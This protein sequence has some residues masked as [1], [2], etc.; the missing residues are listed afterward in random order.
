M[1][2]IDSLFKKPALPPTTGKKRKAE[3]SIN[4]LAAYKSVRLDDADED[5]DS[6]SKDA[7]PADFFDAPAE[8]E[9]GGRFFGGGVDKKQ[10]EILDYVDEREREDGAAAVETIDTAW[11]RRTALAFEK[12]ISKNAEMR[13]KFEDDPH[14]FMASEADLDTDIKALSVLSEHP[15]LFEEFRKLGCLGSLVGLL[16]HENT[17][18][19]IDAVEVISEL[20]D[21]EVE[22]EPEQWSALVD[23]MVEAQLLEMLASNLERLNESIETDRHGVYHTLSVFENLASQQSLA[24]Q[25]VSTTPLL[26]WL[27]TRIQ[28][29]ESPIS[30]NKQYAAELLAILLQ[31]S[32]PN[33]RKLTSLNG[34]DILLQLLSPYRKRDP[35]KGGDEEEFV[36]NIFDALTAIVDEPAGKEKFV[37]AEGVEL[38]LLMLREGRMAKPRALRLLDHAVGGLQGAPVALRI[39]DAA[40]LKTLFGMFMK[41]SDSATTEHLLGIFAALLMLLPAE[42]SARI[43]TLAK[44]VERDYEKIAKLLKLR[45]GYAARL[46]VVEREIAAQKAAMEEEAE[47]DIEDM[48]EEWESRRLD[49]GL[50]CVQVV[51]L[52]LAWLCAEDDAAR[53][54]VKEGLGGSLDAVKRTLEA[55]IG[56]L[57]AAAEADA[58][59]EA[60][61]T[62]DMLSTLV[63]FL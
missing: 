46:G 1:A 32:P 17:D 63:R 29:R 24:D 44:F 27:L 53:S 31:S 2:D 25:I 21:D 26:P 6:S 38:A 30:Q 49:A 23:G 59:G 19:A 14:K 43:R 50:F 20:T 18:I 51:D 52:V 61:E 9:E 37:E 7:L 56:D 57:A 40:G 12:K 54:R 58:E 36:E 3:P 62:R 15:E 13:G 10:A 16:A 41:K 34:V 11:L 48:R 8:D 60:A 35:V 33:R 55:Q 42:S 45:S 39:V 22:A 4:P 28:A 5:G 47:E